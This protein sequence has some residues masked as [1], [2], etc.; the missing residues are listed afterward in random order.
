MQKYDVAIAGGG[1][2]GGYVAKAIASEGFKVALFEEHKQIGAPL[3]C[4]GLVTSRVFDFFNISKKEIVQNEIFGAN[5]HSPSGNI[6]SV[7]GDRVHALAIDR[8]KFD[9]EIMK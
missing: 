7:G 8:P 9:E 3:K 4:A 5:I 6:L 2:V 1:P